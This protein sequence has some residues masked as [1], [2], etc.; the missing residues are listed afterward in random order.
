[1]NQS[2][3]FNFTL[4]KRDISSHQTQNDEMQ[5]ANLIYILNSAIKWIEYCCT[6]WTIL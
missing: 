2:I 4:R 3:Q 5:N 1:M 6:K